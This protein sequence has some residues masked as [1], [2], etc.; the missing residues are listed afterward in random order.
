MNPRIYSL[1]MDDVGHLT[2]EPLP[3]PSGSRWD[4]II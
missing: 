4:S 3:I 2:E 1:S